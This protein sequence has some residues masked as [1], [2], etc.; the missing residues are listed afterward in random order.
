[1]S[2]HYT[3]SLEDLKAAW[4]YINTSEGPQGTD[5]IAEYG[6][7]FDRTLDEFGNE[8]YEDGYSEGYGYG[9]ME[10]YPGEAI[11]GP[12]ESER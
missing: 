7:Q 11:D 2:D 12:K 1:M 10:F 5:D 8:M 9:R 3:P 4:V 6:R